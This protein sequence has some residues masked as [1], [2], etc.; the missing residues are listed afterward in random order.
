MLLER[1]NGSLYYE[2]HGEGAEV[3]VFLNGFASGI[4]NWYPVIKPLKKEYKSVLF[5]YVGTGKSIKREGYEFSFDA[6]CADLRA[7]LD[8]LGHTQNVHL[9]GY[10]MGG[11]ITQEFASRYR[12]RI[13]SLSL[14]NTSS[15]ISARQNW[16]IEH[17]ISVLKVGNLDAFS[18]LMFISYYSPEYFE[19]HRDN[20]I[21]IRNLASA[22]FEQHDLS[23]WEALLESC[24]TF[25]A[26][27]TLPDLNIPIMAL[28]GEHDI[29]CP[30]MTLD[31]FVE[32][33]PSIEN[34]EIAQVGHAIPMEE[35]R[36]LANYLAEFLKSQNV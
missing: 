31:R 6:Y 35:H 36:K 9:V 1:P 25:N 7:L 8:H 22:T 34:H 27:L 32:L 18:Q 24:L 19:K 20:L 5:D 2:L 4:S 21:R 29:L 3:V 26:E 17:F 14:V 11:W 12:D 16:I 13:K 33:I 15:C 30:R 28:S 23:N 10:S